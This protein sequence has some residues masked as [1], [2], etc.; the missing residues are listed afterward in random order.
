MSGEG[1]EV[2]FNSEPVVDDRINRR[3]IFRLEKLAISLALIAIKERTRRERINDRIF[4][5]WPRFD[6]DCLD[7]RPR[8]YLST[9]RVYYCHEYIYIYI[10]HSSIVQ[11][12]HTR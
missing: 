9:S 10:Y 2:K 11:R 5:I 12:L 1:K 6:D 4:I 7:F 8:S 3:S